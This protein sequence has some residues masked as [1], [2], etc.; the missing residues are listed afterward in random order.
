MTIEQKA[1]FKGHFDRLSAGELAFP[2]C[3]ACGKW[4]WYPMPLCPHCLSPRLA[5]RPVRGVGE[6]WSW[7]VVRH[8]FDPTWQGR[9]PYV[10]AL[11]WFADAP[12]IRLVANIEGVSPQALRIGLPVKFVAPDD[13]EHPPR[14]V[15][16]PV[17]SRQDG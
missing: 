7:T 12:G 15:F 5:W 2:V 10:V 9:T 6:I 4:H 17:Q 13:G 16:G 8:P 11:V 3:E 14:P 1:E